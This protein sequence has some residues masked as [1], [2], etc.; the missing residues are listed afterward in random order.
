MDLVFLI[1]GSGS[2]CDR[3]RNVTYDEEGTVITCN[4]WYLVLEFVKNFVNDLDIGFNET[5]VGLV[6]F[7]STAQVEFDLLE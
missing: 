3:D 1:D 7:G 6:Q 4:H 5:R 2:I